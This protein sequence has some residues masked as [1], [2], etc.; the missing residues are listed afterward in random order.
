MHFKGIPKCR[1]IHVSY[2][3]GYYGDNGDHGYSGRA[4]TW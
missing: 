3:Y 4:C 2:D 1:K